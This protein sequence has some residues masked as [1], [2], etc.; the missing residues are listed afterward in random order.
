MSFFPGLYQASQ[1]RAGPGRRS[2]LT[3]EGPEE[4]RIHLP[5]KPKSDKPAVFRKRD[6]SMER[7]PP[8]GHTGTEEAGAGKGHSGSPLT[9]QAPHGPSGNSSPWLEG[10]KMHRGAL[11]VPGATTHPNLTLY[12]PHGWASQRHSSPAK[13]GAHFPV[14]QPS[15]ARSQQLSPLRLSALEILA[16]LTYPNPLR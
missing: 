6:L 2:C 4:P 1:E 11:R 13:W 9:P 14:L 3:Q 15:R 12:C 16:A 10:M 8:G 5:T 7:G